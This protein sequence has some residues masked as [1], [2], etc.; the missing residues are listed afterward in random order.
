YDLQVLDAARPSCAG[1]TATVTLTAPPVLTLALTQKTDLTCYGISTGSLT[2]QGGGGTGA[3]NYIITNTNSGESFTNTSGV[4]TEL[5]AGSYTAVLASAVSGC[6]DQYSYP[7]PVVI[8]QPAE[9]GITLDPTDVRC[10]GEGN[11]NINAIL[12]GGTGPL[13]PVWQQQVNGTWVPTSA[14]V[15]ALNNLLPGSYRLSVTDG[16]T[17]N[18]ISPVVTIIQPDT[19]VIPVV[20]MT[21]IVCYGGSGTITPVATGGN[22]GNIFSFSADG[23]GYTS[24]VPGAAFNA[25]SYKVKVTDQKG[26]VAD[27]AGAQVITAPSSPLDLSS[28]L[29]DYHGYNISCY[30]ATTGIITAEATGGNGSNYS[31]YKYS[32]DGGAWL[33]SPVLNGLA[34]GV[35]AIR[36]QDGRGCIVQQTETL[37][38]PAGEMT[39][40]LLNRKDND[41]VD[42]LAGLLSVSVAGGT[43]PYQFS[44]DGSN[45]QDNGEFAGLSS[46]AYTITA[47]DVNGC[48]LGTDY[49]VVSLYPALS[50]SHMI[51]AVQCNGGSDGRV[52]LEVSGG[53]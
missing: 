7:Q 35:H 50:I 2:L 42:G 10:Y 31:G 32:A 30:G 52:V 49:T 38:E 18:K 15:L 3:Y 19:L 34:A 36:V 28:Q 11:G 40:A 24:F 26:C 33:S 21:D 41:C 20:N 9:I 12:G 47:M 8:S 22:S 29:S 39:M 17:C 27:Y 43:A 25:G 14:G 51:D 44:R 45:Y 13:D 1:Y 23:G 4:F 5:A 16:N 37:T 6:L 48:R 53:F 46:G